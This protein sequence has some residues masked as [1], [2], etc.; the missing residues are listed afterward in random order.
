VKQV[1]DRQELAGWIQVF[2]TV[3]GIPIHVRN[4]LGA[5]FLEDAASRPAADGFYGGLAGGSL[6]AV[7]MLTIADEMAH[8]S[9][10]GALP[11]ARIAG[12]RRMMI[13]SLA[14]EARRR[15]ARHVFVMSSLRAATQY[16][17]LGFAPLLARDAFTA[18]YADPRTRL[19]PHGHDPDLHDPDLHDP[20]LHR[21][22]PADIARN[23]AGSRVQG[24]C[25]PN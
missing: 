21:G 8:I 3:H 11:Q 14:Q 12:A 5:M 4:S 7:G 15:G 20:D 24:M 19:D 6:A 2:G 22:S 17:R 9:F 1:A 23:R 16:E 25:A 10:V 13:L 18:D